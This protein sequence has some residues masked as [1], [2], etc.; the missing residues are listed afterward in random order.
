M[1]KRNFFTEFGRGV[2]AYGL[3]FKMLFTSRFAWFMIFPV[4][5]WILF[6]CLGGL[7]VGWLGNPVEEWIHEGITNWVGNIAWLHNA[8]AVVAFIFRLLIRFAYFML[9]LSVGGYLILIVLSPIYSW[10]SERTETALTGKEYP[11]RFGRFLREM[12]RGILIAI[13]NT[14]FQLLVTVILMLMS[15]IPL[16]GLLTPFLLFLSSAYFY[17]F[18]FVDYTIERRY[19]LVRESVS[20]VN[21]NIGFVMGIGLPFAAALLLPW[22]Q[23]LVCGFVSLASVMAATVAVC[24]N[25]QNTLP[26]S[27]T[28]SVA[29]S[30]QECG[31]DPKTLPPSQA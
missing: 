28:C 1:G 27:Q 8:G 14:F 5:A 21:R 30:A 17:G 4:L 26:P 13:R 19:L 16:I 12:L 10:L 18:S 11:F 29:K 3:A 23:F 6:F 24:E 25:D 31:T 7:L 22:G 2:K 9:F 20:Y 15:F